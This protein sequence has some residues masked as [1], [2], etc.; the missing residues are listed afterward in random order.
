MCLGVGVGLRSGMSKRGA[1]NKPFLVHRNR[2]ALSSHTS[3]VLLHSSDA[4]PD[5]VLLTA[6]VDTLQQDLKGETG[7]A[8]LDWLRC[9]E[10]PALFQLSGGT[11]LHKPSLSTSV[12]INHLTLSQYLA[13]EA[14]SMLAWINGV[15]SRGREGI[16]PCTGHW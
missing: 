9:M 13:E 11:E 16:V 3:A 7:T 1:L 14:T 5:L 8:S 4:L 6:A 15:G 12:W 2:G 10:F